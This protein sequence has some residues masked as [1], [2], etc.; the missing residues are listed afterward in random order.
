VTDAKAT[1]N[2]PC[3]EGCKSARL[4]PLRRGL[5]L[6]GSA[7]AAGGLLPNG[8]RADDEDPG[9][10]M[11]PQVDDQFVRFEGDQEG[12]VITA[13]DLHLGADPIIA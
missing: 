9:I 5:L 12:A 2:K 11:R 13:E 10:K 1:Q 3:S 6:A 4:D 8:G 7:I